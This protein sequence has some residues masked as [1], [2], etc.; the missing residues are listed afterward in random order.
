MWIR[1]QHRIIRGGKAIRANATEPPLSRSF[2]AGLARVLL[3]G[4]VTVMLVATAAP[5]WAGAY[6][7]D[8][9]TSEVAPRD[10]RFWYYHWLA[11]TWM[12]W[13]ACAG[14]VSLLLLLSAPI[15]ESTEWLALLLAAAH[16]LRQLEKYGIDALGRRFAF[17]T[18]LGD[19]L[20]CET[21]LRFEAVESHSPSGVDLLGRPWEGVQAVTIEARDVAG[22]WCG[23]DQDTLLWGGV[24][25]HLILLAPIAVPPSFKPFALMLGACA[26]S[27]DAVAMH[28][29]PS[30]FALVDVVGSLGAA[31]GIHS[32]HSLY[33]PGLVMA[34]VATLPS[35][36]LALTTAWRRTS[37]FNVSLGTSQLV[38]A[39]ALGALPGEAMT[40]LVPLLLARVGALSKPW[41]HTYALAMSVGL[42]LSTFVATPEF[43]ASA[44]ARAWQD[45]RRLFCCCLCPNRRGG[46]AAIF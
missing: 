12:Y 10:E 19:A 29:V 31:S 18:Y 33:N 21:Q 25:F 15:A 2:A 32:Y 41:M 22:G 45:A 34:L 43:L 16:T 40:V 11:S 37:D 17:A 7:D 14:G 27:F 9:F 38:A 26:V 46:A 28:V 5:A 13:L 4:M 36:S 24:Y 6:E 39:F 44:R 8:Y 30:L 23:F 42:A 3:V 35:A 20:G 1:E